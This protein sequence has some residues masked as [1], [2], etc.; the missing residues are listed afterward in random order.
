MGSMISSMAR[1]MGIG[2][3]GGGIGATL[4]NFGIS[5]G[6]G[7]TKSIGSITARN[8]VSEVSAYGSYSLFRKTDNHHQEYYSTSE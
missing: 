5:D 2:Q 6:T 4:G 3:G 1:G 7:S 8:G